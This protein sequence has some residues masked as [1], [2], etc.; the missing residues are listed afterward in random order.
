MENSNPDAPI[1]AP[2]KFKEQFQIWQGAVADIRGTQR[3]ALGVNGSVN[4]G[5]NELKMSVMMFNDL[6]TM[7]NSLVTTG[8]VDKRLPILCACLVASISEYTRA[9]RLPLVETMLDLAGQPQEV[10]DKPRIMLLS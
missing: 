7:H 3:Y 5:S 8:A 1:V 4:E 10:E 2:E 6:M 9:L